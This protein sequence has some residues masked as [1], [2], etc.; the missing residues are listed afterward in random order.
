M[1]VL[2]THQDGTSAREG[3]E[4]MQ[5]CFEQLL[6]FALRAEVEAGGGT[7]QRQQ[8]GQEGN[9]IIAVRT[10]CKQLSEFSE[11]LLDHV[12]ARETGGAFELDDERIERDRSE[13]H[14]SE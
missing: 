4:L 3:F 7:R 2:K 13:E 6:A 12:I 1:G 14:T 5:Q 11:L 9:V 8:L 10:G